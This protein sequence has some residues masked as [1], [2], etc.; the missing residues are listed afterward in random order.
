MFTFNSQFVHLQ[1]WCFLHISCWK[2]TNCILRYSTQ[3]HKNKLRQLGNI[4][5]NTI[6]EI[7]YIA[8]DEFDFTAEDMKRDLDNVGILIGG[9]VREELKTTGGVDLVI[10]DL[11]VLI[12]II[13]TSEIIY[14]GSFVIYHQVDD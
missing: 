5:S 2:S 7:D 6:D 13:L 3:C 14:N 1:C 9:P 10:S 4:F 12:T 11:L 8:V